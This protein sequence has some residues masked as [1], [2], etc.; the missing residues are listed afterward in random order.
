MF[1]DKSSEDN[2]FKKVLSKGGGHVWLQKQKKQTKPNIKA[3][4][5][6]RIKRWLN[7]FYFTK[8]NFS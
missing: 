5:K 6:S 3:E 2:V 7:L 8:K 4:E 1:F